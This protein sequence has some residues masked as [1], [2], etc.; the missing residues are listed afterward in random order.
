MQS[1]YFDWFVLLEAYVNK[2][3]VIDHPGCRLNEFL[4]NEMAK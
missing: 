2:N 4:N 1:V 3:P